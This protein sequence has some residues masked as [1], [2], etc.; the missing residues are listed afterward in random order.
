MI[1]PFTLIGIVAAASAGVYIYQVKHSAALLDRDLR[2]LHRQIETARERTQVLRA[3]WAMLNEPERLRGVAQQ[4]LALEPMTPQQ[5]V[6]QA[7][8]ARRLPAPVLFGGAPSLFSPRPTDPP[9]ASETL[10]ARREAVASAV[11]AGPP[12][13]PAPTQVAAA[14]PVIAPPASVPAAAASGASAIVRSARAAEPPRPAQDP[15]RPYGEVVRAEP[16]SAEPRTAAR[17]APAPTLAGSPAIRP[18][19]HVQPQPAASA[20]GGTMRASLPPPVPI[21]R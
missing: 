17:V 3:E 6:R 18:A 10:V 19:L 7:D 20:L 9:S 15:F 5:F 11:T 13:N 12:A 4:H 16:R 2:N 1:R 8:L 21:A 14:P